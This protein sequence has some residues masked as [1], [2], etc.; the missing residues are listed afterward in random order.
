MILPE[1]R[2]IEAHDVLGFDAADPLA[3]MAQTGAAMPRTFDLEGDMWRRGRY[4]PSLFADS[5]A[6][7]FEWLGRALAEGVPLLPPG[8]H[9]LEPGAF[10]SK[11]ARESAKEEHGIQDR[12]GLTLDD[13]TRIRQLGVQSELLFRLPRWAPPGEF[14]TEPAKLYWTDPG[15]L[16]RA[17]GWDAS[18]FEG[19]IA[20]LTAEQLKMHGSTWKNDS[21][22]GFVVTSLVRCAG[23]RASPSIWRGPDGEIDLILR[24]HAA[25]ETWAIEVTMGRKKSLKSLGL[26]GSE[27]QATRAFI[28]H[29][30]RVGR[31]RLDGLSRY[32]G[33]VECITLRE[34][35]REVRD[36][37]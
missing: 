4:A 7:S 28:V 2:I 34:A 13:F 25:F 18:R 10:W 17:L 31:P 11:M 23:L 24:W 36:G 5:D 37:P 8:R 27:T 30:A 3:L 26:G 1:F 14:S 9:N 6:R 35:L 29:N 20:G 32:T 22:E 19:N 12:S 16:H 15:L 21:W 33:A